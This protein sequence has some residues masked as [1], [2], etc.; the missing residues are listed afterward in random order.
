MSHTVTGPGRRVSFRSLPWAVVA[1]LLA[2]VVVVLAGITTSSVGADELRADP[3]HPTG[4]M[5]GEAR[6]T[7]ADEF[8]TSTP[9]SLG[10]AET[11]RSEDLNPLTAPQAYLNLVPTGPAT[12][13]LFADG[14]A[15]RLG[16]WLPDAML[17]AAKFWLGT[18]LLLLAAPAWFRELTGSRWIG[19]FAAALV[20]LSPANAWWSNTHATLLGFTLAGAVALQR[21]AHATGDGRWWRAGL[22]GVAGAALLVR[23]PLF[24]PPWAVVVVPVVLLGT[25]AG[26]LATLPG[27]RRT[28]AAVG[29]VG[30]LTLLFLAAIYLENRDAI[31]ATS[32]T[33]YPGARV[34]TGSANAVQ[35]LFGATNLRVL[36]DGVEVAGSNS[37]E[38]SS[39]FTVALVL[40]VLLLA[41]GVVWRVPGQRWAVVS[42]MALTGF[43]LLWSTV[44][45]GTFGSR[46]P[47]VNQV[48]SA[49]STQI[50]G[51]LGVLL[52][53][54]VLPAARDRGA[55]SWSLMAAGTT[56]VVAAYAG[57]LLRVQSVP[58][59]TVGGIWLAALALGVT[60]FVLT[61]RP[62]HVAGYALGGV[63]A[64]SLVWQ[65]NPVIVGLGDLRG[66]AVAQRM[67]E[68]GD[69]TRADGGAWATDHYSVDS[70]LMATGVPAFS[71]RQMSGP[72]MATWSRLDPG[73]EHEDVWN[74]GGSY[75][76]FSWSG[77]KELEW[78]NPSP[79]VIHIA[80]SPCV[81]A[82]RLPRLTTVVARREL[83]LDCLEPE[84]S[85]TWGGEERWVY[86][87]V[88]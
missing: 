48:P 13:F 20:L 35:A 68:L 18:L 10:V 1:P 28:V 36:A 38:I 42:M 8:L 70:L 57:S 56:A 75:I 23:T 17:F 16:P 6:S 88:R 76:W 39:G 82:D 59:L 49:R 34:L 86:S 62:R 73:R 67:E 22:W 71:G 43:W 80:G 4:V 84:E 32:G 2:Y 29:G 14:S 11:G 41:R 40:A 45:F 65:V 63:L 72:D 54:L 51:H 78:T 30:A 60:V 77:R 12:A 74:R 24:Y 31:A 64:L 37:S 47:L 21:A 19:W 79:D 3:A 26:L 5:L 83:D 46:I 9:L 66:S 55:R 69:Q 52:L 87:V 53:C 7:R 33:V 81:V 85:F 27:R 58:A 15:L 25:V 61:L 44:D 50:I